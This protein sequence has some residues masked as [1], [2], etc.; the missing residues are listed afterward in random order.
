[1]IRKRIGAPCES[2]ASVR[3]WHGGGKPT[4]AAWVS[5][6]G[7][8]NGR[9]RGCISFVGYECAGSGEPKSMRP[10]STSDVYSSVGTTSKSFVRNSEYVSDY[11][12]GG[13]DKYGRYIRESERESEDKHEQR[14]PQKLEPLTEE[15]VQKKYSSLKEEV[16]EA[17]L[18]IL[19]GYFLPIMREQIKQIVESSR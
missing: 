14:R 3:C 10:S 11:L 4:A 5:T 8:S 7:W 6:G 16:E 9:W 17:G 18:D 15:L 19:P 2:G 13:R 1:M 12:S